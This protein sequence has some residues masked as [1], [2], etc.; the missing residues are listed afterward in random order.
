MPTTKKSRRRVKDD[1]M[2]LKLALTFVN[3]TAAVLR[4]LATLLEVADS[5]EV[6]GDQIHHPDGRA[7]QVKVS[8]EEKYARNRIHQLVG[9]ATIALKK[10]WQEVWVLA[11][12]EFWKE[13]GRHPVVESVNRGLPTHL[14]YVFTDPSWPGILKGIVQKMLTSAPA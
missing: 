7:A 12:H 2:Q 8:A 4:N 5:S 6:E 1:P 9:C 14:D 10:E 11:Y 3:P 13:T